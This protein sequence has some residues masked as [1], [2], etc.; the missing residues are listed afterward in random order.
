MSITLSCAVN[1]RECEKSRAPFQDRNDRFFVRHLRG[2][3]RASSRSDLA[4]RIE[5]SRVNL[6]RGRACPRKPLNPT[7]LE[8]PRKAPLRAFNFSQRYRQLQVSVATRAVE[9]LSLFLP[10]PFILSFFPSF[11]F[12]PSLSLSLSLSL[13]LFPS[14]L[15]CD[16]CFIAK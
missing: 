9:P 14:L 4:S 11:L 6:S 5:A 12:S 3:V 15:F 2:S 10:P 16:G 8:H 13:F 1:R 7:V